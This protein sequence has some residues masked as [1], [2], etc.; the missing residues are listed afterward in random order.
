MIV[1]MRS[2]D[3]LIGLPYD[4]AMYAIL[5]HMIAIVIGRK[6]GKLRFNFGSTHI[7]NNHLEHV[8]ELLAREP[9]PAPS[10]SVDSDAAKFMDL[11]SFDPESFVL[12]GYES[13]PFIKLPVAV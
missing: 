1:N 8:P 10:L 5:L 3:L 7:Y 12:H 4:L 13:H 2:V 11:D 6:P 9:K